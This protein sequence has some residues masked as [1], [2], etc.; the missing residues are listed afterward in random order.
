M[1]A[2][3]ASVSSYELCSVN[4][5]DLV[6]VASILQ[7]LKFFPA[8]CTWFYDLEGEKFDRD[9]LFKPECLKVSLFA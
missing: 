6:L 5:D 8:L 4:L 2:V 7:S 1:L 3:S 9:I